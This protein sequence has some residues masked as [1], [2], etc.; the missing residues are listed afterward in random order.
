MEKTTLGT[1]INSTAPDKAVIETTNQMHYWTQNLQ[2]ALICTLGAMGMTFQLAILYFVYTRIQE[3][4]EIFGDIVET[5]K[6]VKNETKDELVA[7][8]RWN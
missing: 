8:K 4:R 5:P 6:A 7:I 2:K 3:Y 1:Y